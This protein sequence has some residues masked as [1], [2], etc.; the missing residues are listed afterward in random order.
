MTLSKPRRI[1]EDTQEGVRLQSLEDHLSEPRLLPGEDRETY[2]AMAR[3]IRKE[4]APRGLLQRFACNDII[5]LRWEILRHRRLRQKSVER[6][7]AGQVFDIYRAADIAVPGRPKPGEDELFELSEG[8]V[9]DDPDRRD[10]AEAYFDR[11]TGV[12][13]DQVLA[14]AYAEAPTVKVHDAKLNLLM[15]QLRQAMRDYS[16]MKSADARR[17]GPDAEIVED[18]A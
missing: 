11:K 7:V 4:L 16:E 17:D 3:E 13:R 5:D 15:R 18:A 2:K 12:D 6:R 14:E 10:A 1:T 9:S 8:V